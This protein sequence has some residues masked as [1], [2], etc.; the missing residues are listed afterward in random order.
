MDMYVYGSTYSD[1]GPLFNHVYLV[2]AVLAAILLLYQLLVLRRLKIMSTY[3]MLPLLSFCTSYEN[4]A[5]YLSSQHLIHEEH[6]HFYIGYVLH[7]LV[8]PLFLLIMYEVTFRLHEFRN[9][10]FFCFPLEISPSSI[11]AKITLWI[12]RLLCAVLCTINL[13]VEFE[14]FGIDNN[15]PPKTGSA[16]YMYLADNRRE[17]SLWLALIP[18]LSLTVVGILVSMYIYKYGEF[19]ALGNNN[20]WKFASFLILFQFAGQ[21]F[22]YDIYPITSNGGELI[23]LGAITWVVDLMQAEL[24]SA[25]TYADFLN[26]SNLAFKMI[27]EDVSESKRQ[28]GQFVAEYMIKNNKRDTKNDIVRD[29]L[30]N[31]DESDEEIDLELG[32]ETDSRKQNRSSARK[33]VS[34]GERLSKSISGSNLPISDPVTSSPQT[35]ERKSSSLNLAMF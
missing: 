28:S 23:L 1:M 18:S 32:A 34:G 2:F 6:V 33:I 27:K 19:V 13:I 9:A 30:E 3:L 22:S 7:S 10:H 21:C 24:E 12:M 15:D 14:W 8:V 11:F 35:H 31:I 29:N 17:L 20:S 16:G 5:L 25:A 26:R 4:V